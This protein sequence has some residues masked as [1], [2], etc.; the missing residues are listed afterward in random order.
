MNLFGCIG[1]GGQEGIATL[2]VSPD[3]FRRDQRGVKPTN[4]GSSPG[5]RPQSAVETSPI[6]PLSVRKTRRS[7]GAVGSEMP[8]MKLGQH[9]TLTHHG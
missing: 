5:G 3:S 2:M 7:I 6:S 8:K 4:V 1:A 9:L